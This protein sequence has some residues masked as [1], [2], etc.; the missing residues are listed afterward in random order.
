M[1]D[2][3]G[4]LYAG[5]ARRGGARRPR[6]PRP[7]PSV[8]RRPA[9]LHPAR[10][11]AQG[12]ASGSTRSPASC[13]RS[14]RTCR[15]ASSSTAARWPRT[16]AAR[17]SR[18]STTLGGGR[19]SRCH[20]WEQA[21]ELPRATSAGAGADG[22]RPGGRRR[23]CAPRA[24]AR[25]SSR[26]ATR[27]TRCRTSRSR[28]GRARRSGWS[29]SRAAARRR[30]RASCSGL[31]EPDEGSMVELDGH[32]L[33]GQD[34]QARRRRRAGA[35][36]RLPEPGR[37]AQP[38]LLDP[39]HHRP[40]DH[41]AARQ[42]AGARREERLVELAALRPLR[43]AADPGAAG[44]ALGR[45]Q[46]ARGDRA[47]VRGRPARRGLRRAD[48]RA[49]R[50][51][52]GGDPQPARRAADRPRRSRT[53]SSRTT[54][55]SCATCRTASPC[56]T[57]GQL[58]ELGDA[59]TVFAPGAAPVHG[60]AAVLRA[61]R[62]GRAARAHPARGRDPVARPTRR[63][64]ASSTPAARAS[65]ATCASTS[66]P[67]LAE[68]EP[69]HLMRCHIPVE[70]LR[71]AA[72]RAGDSRPPATWTRPTI[73]AAVLEEASAARCAVA[74][75]RAGARPG[76]GEVARAAAR[77]RRLPLG[78]Q[79]D[80]RH[81]ADA[82]P[83][84]A[85]PRGRGRR[86]G[87]GGGRARRRA[88]R[89]RDALLDAGVRALRRV[90]A[91]ARAPVRA[92]VGGH[93]P[94][95]PARRHAAAVARR[96]ARL[97][98][99]VPLHVRRR[100]PSCPPPA[101][102]RSPTTSASTSRRSP[103][104]R[105]RPAPARCGAPR[106]CGRA[107]AWPCSA[108]AASG[109]SARARRGRRRRAPGRRRRR[110]RGDKHEPGAG[111][112]RDARRGL[113][114]GRRRRP[115]SAVIE[116]SGGGVD[117]AIEAT[118]RPEAARAAFLSTRARGAA[119][120]IGIPR[121]DAVLDAAG[122]ADPADGAARARLDLRLVAARARLPGAARA[123]PA[124]AA[125]ARPA[126]HAALGPLEDI[127]DGVRGDARRRRCC[128]WCSTW[129][130]RDGRIRWTAASARRGRARCPT[131]ATSTSCSRGAA[132]PP[133][134]R[135]RARSPS[136][137]PGHVPFLACL[138]AGRRRAADDDRR[139]QVADRGRRDARADHV[140]RRAA[141]DRPGRAR[142]RRRGADRRRPR[143]PR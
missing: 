50:L 1:C 44:G 99:L 103:A 137:R 113:D 7:A 118:G 129:R 102:S 46:A 138:V 29:A 31:T 2:R 75:A 62:R 142:R 13:P 41:E 9:A 57:S 68:V 117:Y 53:C 85:R 104:A 49:R 143:R 10:R 112:R 127:E 95:R 73:R 106:A 36:D 89:P 38:P 122:A 111:A 94:R 12:P 88:G 126:D 30:W 115:P 51:R 65:S 60:G 84:G 77:Q 43:H 37:R 78:L 66:E 86:R 79:R 61:G 125:A 39:A 93:G 133:P 71:D 91:R 100:T 28:C 80:R 82:L 18:R 14:A 67:P 56:S 5:R 26:T 123:L 63:R 119:V 131:A 32:A 6:L 17:R 48:V 33:A 109:M 34:R 81:G 4:V 15:R 98:L 70:E 120:L 69:G 139:Q 97:P 42:A 101:A 87:R 96:R 23:S 105:W 121:A 11:R 54:S 72:G 116:A 124:R 3:V 92:R 22:R 58:M 76:P 141:R 45:P 8:H 132:R 83:G 136:P 114:R 107:T 128:A 19:H 135:P 40:G 55:A 74:G 130:R 110:R 134:R 16:S 47:R 21:H 59:E 20:F 27:S 64:A 90:R 108:A 140:G 24:C 52:A 25:R 35:A